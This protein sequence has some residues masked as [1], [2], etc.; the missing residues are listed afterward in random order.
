[1]ASDKQSK[2]AEQTTQNS[3]E[4]ENRLVVVREKEA[5][6][7]GETARGSRGTTS[8]Y[9]INKSWGCMGTAWQ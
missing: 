9:K 2:R 8:S 1:M 5:G 4:T 3:T 6:E 7:V